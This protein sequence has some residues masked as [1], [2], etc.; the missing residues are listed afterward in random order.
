VVEALLR[1]QAPLTL[2]D[3]LT[4]PDEL[5]WPNQPTRRSPALTAPVSLIVTLVTWLPVDTVPPCT[6]FTLDDVAAG[7][8]TCRPGDWAEWLPAVS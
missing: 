8:V 6:H 7:V 3:T 4:C 5:Y 2:S 1:V